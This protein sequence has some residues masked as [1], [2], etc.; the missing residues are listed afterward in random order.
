LLR[1]GRTLEIPEAER[2]GMEAG[3]LVCRDAKGYL[4]RALNGMDVNAYGTNPAIAQTFE[5]AR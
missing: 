2:A 5:P 1:N 3:R 4:V